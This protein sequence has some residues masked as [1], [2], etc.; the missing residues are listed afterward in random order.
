LKILVVLV[1]LGGG[2]YC[3]HWLKNPAY[4]AGLIGFAGLMTDPVDVLKAFGI[5]KGAKP[6]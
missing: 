4:G 6:E 1:A 3:L 2:I 5:W